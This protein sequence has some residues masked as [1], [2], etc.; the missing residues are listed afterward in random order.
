MGLPLFSLEEEPEYGPPL[1]FMSIPIMLQ[2][3][4]DGSLTQKKRWF[5]AQYPNHS[6]VM[7]EL[8]NTN[9]IHA[10]NKFEE[11]EFVERFQC[12]FRLVDIPRDAFY[13]LEMP[14][15]QE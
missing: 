3:Y 12:Y 10:F 4:S 1:N 5:K 2:E 6:P 14:A 8:D 13:V 11:E 7:E 15:T 9:G